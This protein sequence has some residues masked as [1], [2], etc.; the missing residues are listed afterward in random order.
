MADVVNTT[1]QGMDY[2]TGAVGMVLDNWWVIAIALLLLWWMSRHKQSRLEDR[3]IN[4]Q[5][6]F[7]DVTIQDVRDYV[8]TV[9]SKS[10]RK[11][12][13][14]GIYIGLVDME[15]T[16]V[17]EV[18][19]GKEGS[20]TKEYLFLKVWRVPPYRVLGMELGGIARYYIIDKDI[21]DM[22]A[23]MINIPATVPLRK[24]GGV[25]VTWTKNGK[26]RASSI[27]MDFTFKRI[28]EG[29]LGALEEMAKHVATYHDYL[30]ASDMKRIE[31]EGKYWSGVKERE[32]DKKAVGL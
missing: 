13:H 14:N 4:T 1:V 18:D 16:Y 15:A 24:F 3:I 7:E 29:E 21:V 22:N 19:T 32:R 20:A 9:G 17:A 10:A 27:V 30:M 25:W 8:E 2:I 12:F 23:D 28:L 6:T 31:E 5:K 11:L 26:A